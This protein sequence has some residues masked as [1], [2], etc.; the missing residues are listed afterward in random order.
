MMRKWMICASLLLAGFTGCKDSD[1]DGEKG[2]IEP[3]TLTVAASTVNMDPASKT[4]SV[5]IEFEHFE[6]LKSLN[7]TKVVEEDRTTSSMNQSDLTASYTYVYTYTEGDPATFAL[8]FVAVSTD[9]S[10]SEPETVQVNLP[11]GAVTV[12]LEND[13]VDPG[14]SDEVT[15]KMSIENLAE[16]DYIQVERIDWDRTESSKLF[17]ADLTPDYTFSYS[18]KTTDAD[19]FTFTFE[20]VD[21]NGWRSPVQTLK[22][23][24]RGGLGFKN[25]Q[26]VS[27]VTGAE[28][29]DD[30]ILPATLYKV[31]NQTD[32]RFNVGGTDL[33]IVW[34]TT[35]G[36]YGLF[37]GDTYG[38]SFT[39]VYNGG[40]PGAA[41]GWRCNVLLFSEDDDLSDG[42]TIDDAALDPLNVNRAR[43]IIY[44]A[45][46]VS[47]NGDWTSIPTS[48]IRAN[49]IDYVHYF[50]LKTWTGWT[51]NYSGLYRSVD[52]GLKWA[53]CPKV[54]FSSNSNFGMVGFGKNGDGYVYI[55][56]TVSGRNSQPKLARVKETEI[57]DLSNYE[58][59]NGQDWV[60]DNEAAAVVLFDDH[61]GELSIAYHPIYGKWIILYF[62]D[63]A[64][65]YDVAM[66]TANDI[67]GPWSAPMEVVHGED[68][69]QLYGSYIHPASLKGDK[70]YFVMSMWV[71]Y[72]TYLMSID[73][74]RQ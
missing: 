4:A 64:Y 11:E 65:G 26:C 44:G 37:F 31:D 23:D 50:N 34:E 74:V 32:Q 16:L 57:E 27:R 56:G 68:Y 69:A 62:R 66:R 33:G 30:P 15:V 8:E 52:N 54:T 12:T 2:P 70:L 14:E 39:P 71:P 73:L 24:R 63:V 43:E 1:S 7:V 72:N 28:Q 46:D 9:G 20:A 35:P 10:A 19:Y 36:R 17:A 5:A 61:A 60:K 58:Y 53:R 3:A 22:V 21:V 55:V 51:T 67:T 40:G 25:L 41:G 29:T 6:N 18:F 38:R 42:M 49:G 59:W 47:G 13:T 45:K 48:A